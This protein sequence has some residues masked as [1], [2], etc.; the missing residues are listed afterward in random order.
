MSVTGTSFTFI[1]S[2]TY[3]F[4]LVVA[5]TSPVNAD[6]LLFNGVVKHFEINFIHEVKLDDVLNVKHNFNKFVGYCD[7]TVSFK[8]ECTYF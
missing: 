4:A 3:I 5:V 2:E 1:P 7:E 8:A 6:M